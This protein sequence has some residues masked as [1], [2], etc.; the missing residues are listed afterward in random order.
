MLNNEK[1]LL[2]KNKESNF[3]LYAIFF[4]ACFGGS[5][6]GV[7]VGGRTLSFYRIFLLFSFVFLLIFS[8]INLKKLFNSPSSTFFLFICV[9]ILFSLV[10]LIYVKDFLK[11]I[12]YI[13]VLFSIL[14]L[15]IFSS[16]YINKDNFKKILI[17]FEFAIFINL[18]FALYEIFTGTYII[19]LTG[20]DLLIYTTTKNLLNTNIPIALFGNPNN[21]ALFC[22]ISFIILLVSYNYK[23]TN[24]H[25]I[26]ICILLLLD[27]FIL[28]A[29]DSRAGLF[30][31]LLFIAVSIFMISNKNLKIIYS[32]ILLVVFL[33]LLINIKDIFNYFTSTSGS[34]GSNSVRINLILN[35][36]DMLI[37]TGLMGVGAGNI[38]INMANY[39][40]TE[41][42]VNMHNFIVEILVS[43]GIVTFAFFVIFYF[44][45]LRKLFCM[46]RYKEQNY[47]IALILFSGFF[48]F[49]L[50]SLGP[51]SIIEIDTVWAFLVFIGMFLDLN[52]KERFNAVSLPILNE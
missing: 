4:L 26:I 5:T 52:F 50:A 8:K 18:F 12:K 11:S 49:L 7:V 24:I 2:N 15:Y 41:G 47:K 34:K 29:T 17:C 16:L 36:L 31:I 23:T 42:I 19:Q 27:L 43:G 25:K 35:G 40:N 37:K 13:L 45:F 39:T 6:L 38:E 48:A 3:L 30:S 22:F 51:S 32:I 10:Q 44:T 1:I 33:V 9:W 14:F 21:L 28:L 46:Y 20:E